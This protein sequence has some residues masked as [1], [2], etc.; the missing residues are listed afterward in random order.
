[1]GAPRDI[2]G[3]CVAVG[4]AGVLLRGPSG[5]GKSALALALIETARVRGLFARLVADDRVVLGAVHGRLVARPH[6]GLAGLVEERG[7][8]IVPV[9]HLPAVVVRLVVDL[10]FAPERLPER[11]EVVLEG[12]ALPLCT[13][14]AGR[15]PAE[16][17]LRRL[18][19]LAG[20][21]RVPTIVTY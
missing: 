21:G 14:P 2:H 12:I 15:T 9:P 17:V 3:A 4:E 13:L 10:A 7:V 6:P 1:M 20:C 11:S 16:T 19:T 18:G 5:S 8:G